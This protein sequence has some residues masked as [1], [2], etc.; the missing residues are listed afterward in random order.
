MYF[1]V[2]V[3]ARI[4]NST[5]TETERQTPFFAQGTIKR[6]ACYISANNLTVEAELRLRKN[7]SNGNSLLTIPTGYTGWV[8]DNTNTDTVGNNVPDLF[9]AEMLSTGNSANNT[10]TVTMIQFDFESTSTLESISRLVSTGRN[11]HTSASSTRYSNF[12]GGATTN[13]SVLPARFRVSKTVKLRKMGIFI[14]GNTRTTS[15]VFTANLNDVATSMSVT[16]PA[17]GTGW[18]YDTVNEDRMM[19]GN[20]GYALAITTG[21]GTEGIQIETQTIE[22]VSE[23]RFGYMIWTQTP[24][25]S[26]TISGS[27]TLYTP[28]SGNGQSF[29]GSTDAIRTKLSNDQIFSGLEVNITTA[30][31]DGAVTVRFR[32]NGVN[33]NQIISIPA[34]T[35]GRFVDDS[36]TD[37][38]VKNDLVEYS[39][40]N[41]SATSANS[42]QIRHLHTHSY[43]YQNAIRNLIKTISETI[44]LSHTTTKIED[45]TKTIT[46]G[47]S[48]SD[49]ENRYRGRIPAFSNSIAFSHTDPTRTK[50]KSKTITESLALVDTYLRMT[51]RLRYFT[52]SI[53][54]TD[55]YTRIR[56]LLNTVTESLGL[57][58]NVSKLRNKLRNFTDNIT[59]TDTR[60]RTR[61]LLQLMSDSVSFSDTRSR[62]RNKIRLLEESMT[63]NHTTSKTRMLTAVFSQSLSFLETMVQGREGIRT[64]AHSL[65]FAETVIRSKR[66]GRSISET[67]SLS[68]TTTGI[69]AKLKSITDTV[70]L[71]HTT[72]KFRMLLQPITET[73]S[74]SHTTTGTIN[75]IRAFTNSLSLAHTTTKYRGKSK[76]F[77]NSISFAH[78]L[79]TRIKSILRSF[80][81]TLELVALH[82]I[83]FREGTIGF[84]ETLT[85]T[86]DIVKSKT[87]ATKTFI[88]TLEFTSNHVAEKYRSFF[89]RLFRIKSNK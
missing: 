61:F 7:G 23:D 41:S 84:V 28:L 34:N 31:V 60:T 78:L 64:I 72:E 16:V 45:K 74:I 32:K 13:S 39:V 22:M 89:V 70:N 18:F 81:E 52:N 68:H 24:S 6:F 48:L 82:P 80:T 79:P 83:Q 4:V 73:L 44:S 66:I 8:E 36:N 27:S 51:E 62:L 63:L 21:A 57:T 37:V 42:I 58:E 49:T 56:S 9:T 2:G 30:S 3:S 77:T 25:G 15:T 55:S 1:P 71:N 59:L 11:T 86:V 17:G 5:T 38:C 47:I 54:L 67:L 12:I 29:S 40:N 14:S 46:E 20:D 76:Q 88:E 43:N 10:L 85:L 33:G 65:Q 35:T 19:L 87:L 69:K 53:A 75:R 26:I 50:G